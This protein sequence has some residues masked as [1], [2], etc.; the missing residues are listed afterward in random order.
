M[1]F[2]YA[3]KPNLRNVEGTIPYSFS[4]S[5]LFVGQDSIYRYAHPSTPEP[6]L[7]I[8][9]YNEDCKSRKYRTIRHH[10]YQKTLNNTKMMEEFLQ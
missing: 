4:Q 8:A 3:V 9:D 2:D 7:T 10:N 5:G 6:V 1:D